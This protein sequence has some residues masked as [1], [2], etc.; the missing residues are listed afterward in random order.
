MQDHTYLL[1]FLIYGGGRMSSPQGAGL[2]IAE[3]ELEDILNISERA[4]LANFHAIK[5]GN[6]QSFDA[7]HRTASVQL[8]FMF[9]KKDGSYQTYPKLVD[10]PVFTLQ[11]GGFSVQMPIS[12]GDPCLVLF[13]DRNIDAWFAGG[14]VQPPPDGS[15]HALGDAI[16][17]VGV[18]W[19]KDATIAEYSGSEARMVDAAGTTKV[20]MTGGKITVQNAAQNLA[21]ILANLLTALESLT[22]TVSGSTG[23]VSAATVTA[24]EAVGTALQALLY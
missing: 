21:T 10:C 5:I 14:G 11:G 13:A 9:Q 20:G 18:N 22:V 23:T 7:T 1:V 8:S 12:A 16:A 2:P 19:Q 6:I 17:L 15:M 4:L 24:L 3:P